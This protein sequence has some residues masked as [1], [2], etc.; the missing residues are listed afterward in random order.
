MMFHTE[1]STPIHYTV[2]VVCYRKI[3]E[4]TARQLL[5]RHGRLRVRDM[6]VSISSKVE[7]SRCIEDFGTRFVR[8]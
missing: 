1:S 6:E 2:E 3:W 7:S 8:K 4:P 5:N